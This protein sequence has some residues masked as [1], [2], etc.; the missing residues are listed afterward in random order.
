MP[1]EL[2]WILPAGCALV[3][4]HAVARDDRRTEVWAKPL[5]LI[6]L[7][8]VALTLGATD[9]TAGRWL[10]VA[11]VLGLVGDIALLSESM[12]RFQVGLGA[13]LIGHLAYLACFATLGLPAPQW[14]W[15]GLIVPV[16]T[17]IAIRGVVPSAHRL[18]GTRVSGPVTVYVAVI[19]AM[20]VG[21]WFTGEP[22]VAIG[23]TV[24]VASDAILAVNRFVRP[25]PGARLS[26]IVTYQLGQALITAGVLGG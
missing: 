8:V 22:L 16:V 3:D 14:S 10:L 2:I 1:V 17:L 4:W 23:A 6:S 5:V 19:A 12:L 15:A 26:L 9:D 24:F 13:F 18:G 11:L 25:L 7:I 21:A 20:L